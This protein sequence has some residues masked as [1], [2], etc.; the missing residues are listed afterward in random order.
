MKERTLGLIILTAILCGCAQ[1]RTANVPLSYAKLDTGYLN[2]GIYDLGWIFVWDRT[3]ATLTPET[4]LKVPKT[5]TDIGSIVD[6][7]QTNLASD[8]DVEFS[9][10]VAKIA[11]ATANL[12]SEIARSTSTELDKVARVAV[13]EPQDLLNFNNLPSRSWRK[14]LAHDYPGDTFRFVLVD[15]IMRGNKV[16]VGFK[17]SVNSSVGANVLQYGDLKVKVT[18]SGQNNFTQTGT[19]IPLVFHARMFKLVGESNDPQFA[20]VTGAEAKQFN[21]Q[22]AIRQSQ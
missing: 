11:G 21:F 17:N 10:D 7:Q 12:K 4:H 18:Y 22:Q 3:Q 14:R 1:T 2:S 16:S 8:T 13:G 15:A 9:A 20:P 19:N 5:L 6:K